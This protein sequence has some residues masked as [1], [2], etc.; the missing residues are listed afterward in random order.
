MP[1]EIQTSDV[2][3]TP[4]EPVQTE[5][6]APEVNVE[7]P[8]NPDEKWENV[9]FAATTEDEP[10][11]EPAKA[12]TDPA[13]EEDPKSDGEATPATETAD[14]EQ[15]DVEG[16]DD[17][18]L[19]TAEELIASGGAPRLTRKQLNKVRNEIVEPFRNPDV[20]I[21]D[22]RQALSAFAP[23]R[24]HE[25]ELAIVN[26]SAENYP[27]AWAEAITGIEG[28]TVE[29]IKELAANPPAQTAPTSEPSED[30]EQM[31]TK[32]YGD[33][34]KDSANDAELDEADRPIAALLRHIATHNADSRQRDSEWEVKAKNLEEQLNTL[35][36]QVEDFKKAQEAD[37]T[38]YE[39]TVYDK[40]VNE[41]R[42]AVEGR[43][44]PAT[45]ADAGLDVSENDTDTVKAVK[46]MV[47]GLFTPAYEGT[48]SQF[49][50][51]LSNAYSG[52]E[53]L[54]K[55]I[56]RVD[57]LIDQAATLEATAEK[58]A[59]TPEK[60]KELLDAAAQLW[61]QANDDRDALTVMHKQ[62]AKEFVKAQSVPMSLLEE[63]AQLRRQLGLN[64]KRVEVTGSA[65]APGKTLAERLKEVEGDK[66]ESGVAWEHTTAQMAR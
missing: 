58:K 61:A 64:G 20:P 4:A 16:D 41:Y 19:P 55:A 40:K 36:P 63:N 32:Y 48:T 17:D 52:R 30:V 28:I 43:V 18:E 13:T 24:M 10:P 15:P 33:K 35:T 59:K 39:Q 62:A 53:A 2:L 54:G 7:T 5:T 65:S 50:L 31:L 11:G 56:Q 45:F 3:E 14:G 42:S 25:L 57:K 22:V 66:W 6:P 44:M 51:F 60:A 1:E 21:T 26:A 34:W 29:R 49:D 38:R 23:Q 8:V 37:F 12:Q 47:K 46:E 9:T 27:D